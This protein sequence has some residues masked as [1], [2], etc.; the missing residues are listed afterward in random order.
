MKHTAYI[1]KLTEFL[2]SHQCS[3]FH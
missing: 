2:T 1:D 3:C